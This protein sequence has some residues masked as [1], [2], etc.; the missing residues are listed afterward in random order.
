MPGTET[1]DHDPRG[2]PAESCAQ[3]GAKSF[4]ERRVWCRRRRRLAARASFPFPR[5][6]PGAAAGRGRERKETATPAAARGWTPVTR[7]GD[8]LPTRV[9]LPGDTDTG[10]RLGAHQPA[11]ERVALKWKQNTKSGCKTRVGGGGL[12]HAHLSNAS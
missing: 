4:W 12:N 6:G 10:S 8:T 3:L 11:A 2:H 5:S 7:V 1:R 9:A